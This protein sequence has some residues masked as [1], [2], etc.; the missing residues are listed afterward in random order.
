MI[1]PGKLLTLILKWSGGGKDTDLSSV[2][3]DVLRSN[4]LDILSSKPDGHLDSKVREEFGN[5]LA[6]Y[7]IRDDRLQKD[8]LFTIG[9]SVFG[10]EVHHPK[11]EKEDN[12]DPVIIPFE[13]MKT[14]MKDVFISYGVPEDR[15]EVCAEVLIE[16]DRRG[17]DSHGLGRLKPIYCDRM[18]QGILQP[19][20]PIDVVKETDT[21]ALL[22][23]N[24]GI[25]LYIGPYCMQLAIEKAKKHGVG[26]VVVRNS[27]HYG[28]AGYY[29][30]Q[31][32]SQGCIGWSGTN[33]R[34]SIA[35]TFGVEPMLG[36]NPLCFGI[37]TDE[38]FDF[39]IDCA[40]SI[41]QRGKIERYGRE[42]IDTPKGVV[43]DHEGL[44]RT[45]TEGILRDMVMGKCALNPVGGAGDKTAGTIVFSILNEFGPKQ[46]PSYGLI[47]F[48]FFYV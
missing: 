40:T 24:L 6:E 1:G 21:T 27:T 38:E 37:P 26:F 43:V 20:M 44:E 42:G 9:S 25:G 17:I 28:I 47:N 45:D 35:P 12:E 32:T 39:V 46:V 34:P 11:P 3:S 14:F 8:I 31:A 29:V 22:D 19:S 30:T 16:S 2:P 23:G 7:A 48:S 18:D 15:A 4:L 33:A 5:L 13:Y 10:I 36:T 41:N